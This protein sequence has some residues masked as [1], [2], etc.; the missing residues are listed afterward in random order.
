MGWQ[1]PHRHGRTIPIDESFDRSPTKFTNGMKVKHQP[2][3]YESLLAARAIQYNTTTKVLFKC[4][5]NRREVASRFKSIP[6]FD[7][8]IFARLPSIAAG[9]HAWQQK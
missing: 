2:T 9:P 1:S 6:L 5:V 8:R 7:E 3:E 4:L